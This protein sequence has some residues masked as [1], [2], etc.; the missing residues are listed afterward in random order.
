[1][2]SKLIHRSSDGCEDPPRL[3]AR[4]QAS[5]EGAEKG[6][7]SIISRIR[8]RLQREGPEADP[9]LIYCN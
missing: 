6:R 3:Q 7:L 4:V 1:M 2:P 8:S 9:F 5:L